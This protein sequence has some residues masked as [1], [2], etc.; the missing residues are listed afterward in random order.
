MIT[1]VAVVSVGFWQ[2]KKNTKIANESLYDQNGEQP[3]IHPI[4]EP[5]PNS[6]EFKIATLK[7]AVKKFRNAKTFRAT[8]TE[9]VAEGKMQGELSYMAPLRLQ[10]ELSIDKKT[11]FEMIVV[12]E[13]AYAKKPDS[14]WK[15][16]NDEAIKQFG[17][18][19]FEALLSKDETLTSFG[20]EDESAIEIKENLKEDC[21]EYKAEYYIEE[22][23]FN[24]AICVDKTGVIKFIKKQHPEGES[25]IYYRDYNTFFTIERP[26][27]PILDRTQEFVPVE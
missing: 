4:T 9:D 22:A 16:T 5:D 3:Y 15:M 18:N 21:T 24:I 8:I 6:R 7:E 25:L 12:G 1:F 20:I 26:V 2:A 19:F 11:A 17:R 27:L 23:V 14:E 10:A 13:T